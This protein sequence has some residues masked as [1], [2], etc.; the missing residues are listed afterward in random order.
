MQTRKDL[1][2]GKVHDQPHGDKHKR[3]HQRQQPCLGLINPIIPP[4]GPFRDFIR[5]GPAEVTKDEDADDT[6]DINEAV[7]ARAHEI[8]RGLE[9]CRR[10]IEHT[11][12]PAQG[13]GEGQEA[14]D[15]GGV[16]HEG[17]GTQEQVDVAGV[18]VNAGEGAQLLQEG[19]FGGGGCY[20]DFGV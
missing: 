17:P 20:G 8:G 14:E 6:T 18:G 16:Q 2:I 13:G 15:R 11:N 12:V 3:K 7:D 1:R 5:E 19:E 4:R 9:H 10:G